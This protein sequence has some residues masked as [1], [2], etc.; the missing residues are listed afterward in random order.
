MNVVH[1]A[2]GLDP[3]QGEDVQPSAIMGHPLNVVAGEK[4]VEIGEVVGVEKTIEEGT[5]QAP[6]E[7]GGSHGSLD[8]PIFHVLLSDNSSRGEDEALGVLVKRKSHRALK[9]PDPPPHHQKK[10]RLVKNS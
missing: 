1:D 9:K 4:V 10:R 3:Q 7:V 8:T 6:C 2:L 5:Q